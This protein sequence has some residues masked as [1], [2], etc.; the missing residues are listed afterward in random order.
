MGLAIKPAQKVQQFA[1]ICLWGVEKQGKTHAALELATALVG[2][3]GPIGVISSERGSS[4]LLSRNYPHDV[5]D[6]MRDEGNNPVRNPF[7]ARRY[8]EAVTAFVNGGYPVIIVDSLSHLWEGEG[9]ILE[10]VQKAG[11]EF[12]KGWDAGSPLYQKCLNTL[13][14]VPC[15]LIVTLRAKDAYELEEYTKKDGKAGKRPKNVGMAPVIRKYFGYEMQFMIRMEDMTG[16]IVS[17]AYQEEL[18]KGMEIESMTTDFAPAL[19]RFLEGVAPPERV[20]T[21]VESY[22]RG[23]LTGAWSRETFYAT[24]SRQLGVLVSGNTSLEAEQ[25]KSLAALAE[26]GA[27]EASQ[28][29]DVA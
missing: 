6:L 8:E 18:P 14:S 15:H 17:S 22:K 28:Q 12:Q 3:R 21:L 11:G 26:A 1:R 27:P 16:Q 5:A 23:V 25:L 13:L 19:L 10:V 7:S 9:G 20:P 24:A 4:A 2:E 29:S